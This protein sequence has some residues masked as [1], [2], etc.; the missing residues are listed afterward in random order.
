MAHLGT[1]RG[2]GTLYVNDE[3]VGTVDYSI[4][5]FQARVIKDARGSISGDPKALIAAFNA[6]ESTLHLE[7]GGEVKII[8]TN[9]TIGGPAQI[10]VSGPVPGF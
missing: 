9:H 1:I 5:V 2:T 4:S 6:G 8:I 10:V 7:D 3:S